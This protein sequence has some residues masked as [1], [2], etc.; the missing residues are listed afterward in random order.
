MKT[1]TEV[2]AGAPNH[3]EAQVSTGLRV[4]TNLKAGNTLTPGVP[5]AMVIK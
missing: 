2:K 1:K 4:R 5:T 3:N